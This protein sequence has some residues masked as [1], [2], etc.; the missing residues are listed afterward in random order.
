MFMQSCFKDVNEL[1]PPIGKDDIEYFTLSDFWD[2]YTEWSA[3]G[4]G[5]PILLNNGETVVQYYVPY[6]SAIQI[7]SNKPFAA[8]RF[9]ILCPN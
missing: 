4:A 5:C 2:N 9:A 6:L 1:W 7:Y 8:S 3:Y